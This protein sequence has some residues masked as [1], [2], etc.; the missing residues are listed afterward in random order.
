MLLSETMAVFLVALTLLTAYRFR[1]EPSVL[2]A[3]AFGV[4]T[5]LAV[6]TRTELLLL[7]PVLVVPF[8]LSPRV[9]TWKRRL[10]LLGAA[11]LAAAVLIGPWVGYNLSRFHHAEFIATGTGAAMMSGSCDQV[12]Y[13]SFIG[14][15]ANCGE[16][17][18]K[19]GD[20]SDDDVWFRR[21]AIDYAKHHATRA[22]LVFAARAGRIWG[23]FKPGQEIDLT[24][25]LEGQGHTIAILSFAAYYVLMP[26]AIGGIVLIRRRRRAILPLLALAGIVTFSAVSTTGILRYRTPADVAIVLAAAVGI[27]AT[28]SWLGARRARRATAPAGI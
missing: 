24:G 15:W 28:I 19:G 4:A 23:V 8:A 14:Y 27:D 25:G 3:V 7:F 1:D 11:L 6:L 16:Y 22:P 21:H 10:T 9:G 12:W 20:E 26:F 18:K 17:P 2:A 13:G 5:A